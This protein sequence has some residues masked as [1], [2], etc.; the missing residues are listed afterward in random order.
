MDVFIWTAKLHKGRLAV[1]LTA[2]LILGI[3]LT[4]GLASASR[5]TAATQDI[6]PKGVKTAEAR[7]AYLQAWGWQ[8]AS[9]A[10]TVEE[11]ALPDDFGEEYTGYLELQAAQGFDLT[12]YAGKRV[13]RY[14]YEVQ[15]HPSGAGVTAHL[16]IY[17][18]RVVGGELMGADFLTGLDGE[19][20]SES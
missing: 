14:T 8:V 5:P 10:V 18:N 19:V 11:L 6:D 4:A 1:I 20:G 2:L 12:K 16:L 15:N 9:E 17:R 3:G 13:K 7:V